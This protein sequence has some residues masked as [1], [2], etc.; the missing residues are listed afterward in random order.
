[1]SYSLNS[2]KG[3]YTGEYYRRYSGRY[4][5]FRHWLTKRFPQESLGKVSLG[6]RG[7][8]VNSSHLL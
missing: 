8:I 7:Y 5:E 6:F 1:M 3:G 2:F 4:Q